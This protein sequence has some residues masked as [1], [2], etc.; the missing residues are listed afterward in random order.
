MLK[1][2]LVAGLQNSEVKVKVLDNL[3]WKPNMSLVEIRD[4]VMQFEQVR[5][6]VDVTSADVDQG[7]TMS[8][9]YQRNG[10]RLGV[11]AN[12][13]AQCMRLVDVQLMVSVVLHVQK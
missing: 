3:Q 8:I 7:A 5:G 10:L 2:A 11:N 9:H 6:F 12:F 4:F 1:V 13:V